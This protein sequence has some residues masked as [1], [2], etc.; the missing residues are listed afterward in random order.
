MKKK[1]MKKAIKKAK[2][3]AVKKALKSS[4][5]RAAKRAAKVADEAARTGGKNDHAWASVEK[6]VKRARHLIAKRHRKRAMSFLKEK[7]AKENANKNQPLPH[8]VWSVK[9]AAEIKA[10][11]VYK[12]EHANRALSKVDGM[13]RKALKMHARDPIKEKAQKVAKAKEIKLKK[14]QA[15]HKKHHKG[16]VKPWQPP[17]ATDE[18]TFFNVD[19]H[20]PRIENAWNLKTLMSQNLFEADGTM[21]LGK[22]ADGTIPGVRT[23]KDGTVDMERMVPTPMEVLV[24]EPEKASRVEDASKKHSS[25]MKRI[26]HLL[27][28]ALVASRAYEEIFG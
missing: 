28:D 25:S 14:Q 4:G 21:P 6:S 16:F 5:A 10:K 2:K 23:N 18:E 17:V 9:R 3:K 15:A 8:A 24:D 20:D 12:E 27:N 22:E 11:A 19:P 1:A 7:K 13:A 26:P